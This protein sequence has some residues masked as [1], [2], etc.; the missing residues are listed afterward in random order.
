M[1][2]GALIW[3]AVGICSAGAAQSAAPIPFDVPK[4]AKVVMK[5][6]RHVSWRIRRL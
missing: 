2:P 6:G 1:V 4:H 5:K 3:C